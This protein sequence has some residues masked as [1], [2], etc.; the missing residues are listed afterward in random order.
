MLFT[1]ERPGSLFCV[2]G[3]VN[4]LEG[5]SVKPAMVVF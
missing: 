1:S 5:L 2:F 3:G 4:T